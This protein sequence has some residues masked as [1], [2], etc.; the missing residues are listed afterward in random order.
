MVS[1]AEMTQEEEV[2]CPSGTM[3]GRLGEE[4]PSWRPSCMVCMAC[5]EGIHGPNSFK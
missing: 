3:H 1:F 5:I 2:F 4:L